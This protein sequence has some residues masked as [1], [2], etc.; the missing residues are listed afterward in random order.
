MLVGFDEVESDVAGY[1]EL[2][3]VRDVGEGLK[4]VY[5]FLDL[6]EEPWPFKFADDLG[7]F[8]D[9][10]D[11]PLVADA[12]LLHSLLS[13][14]LRI[15][16]HLH[17]VIIIIGFAEGITLHPNDVDI[18]ARTIDAVS[19]LAEEPLLGDVFEI[20][21]YDLLAPLEILREVLADEGLG[22]TEQLEWFI[23]G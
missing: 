20:R 16:S 5:V 10:V 12:G 3:F 9:G 11:F 19:I 2:E 7:A 23:H 13:H 6:V 17:R 4:D 15:C 8:D 21:V 18:E 1:V 14:Y 22:L